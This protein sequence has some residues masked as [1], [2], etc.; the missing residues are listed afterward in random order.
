MRRMALADPSA[1]SAGSSPVT[2]ADLDVLRADMR[3]D[4]ERMRADLSGEIA[5]LEARLLWR[6]L[7][8]LGA[9]LALFR[10]LD[11]LPPT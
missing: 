7:G 6:L 2:R 5:R 10:L 8:A 4:L 1:D 9:L 3:A 11:F